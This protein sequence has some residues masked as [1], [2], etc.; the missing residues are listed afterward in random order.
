VDRVRRDL[1]PLY[2]WLPDGA[3]YHDPHAYLASEEAAEAPP[4]VAAVAG[5]RRA[6]AG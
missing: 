2:E 1:G 3:M 5:V 4:R 6:A